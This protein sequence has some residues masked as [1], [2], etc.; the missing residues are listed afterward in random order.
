MGKTD[1]RSGMCFAPYGEWKLGGSPNEKGVPYLQEGTPAH[2]A[3]LFFIVA[4]CIFREKSECFV[5]A[6]VCWPLV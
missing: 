2:P 4:R 1:R 6:E 5:V 3:L